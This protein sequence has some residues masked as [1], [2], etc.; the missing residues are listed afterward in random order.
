[1]E[2]ITRKPLFPGKGE[3]EQLTK[4]FEI[5]GAPNEQRWAGYSEL[6]GAQ[7]LR[8]KLG[9]LNKLRNLFP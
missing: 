6:P 7:K 5:L 3:V 1:A 9:P 4:I 8:F 2:L